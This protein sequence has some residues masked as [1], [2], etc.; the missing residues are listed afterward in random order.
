MVAEPEGA[1]EVFV[2]KGSVEAAARDGAGQTGPPMILHTRQSRRFARGGAGDVSNSDKKLAQFLRK[3]VMERVTMPAGYVHWSFDDADGARLSANTIGIPGGKYEAQLLGSASPAYV[4]GKWGRALALNGDQ[5]ARADFPGINQRN[6]RTVAFWVN[7]PTDALPSQA[8]SMI[9]WQQKGARGA[10][11]VNIGWNRNPSE[12]A[13]GAL[14]TDF[15]AGYMVGATPLRDGRWHHL[16]VVISPK[17]KTEASVQ[18]RQYVDGRLEDA[19]DHHPGKRA[20]RTLTAKGAERGYAEEALWIG[21]SVENSASDQQH[22]VGALD[23]LFV[24]DRAL[25]PQEIRHLM[26]KNAPAPAE[27]V[28][29]E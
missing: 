10:Y 11:P 8:D 16:A 29:L 2:L 4:A 27:T 6:S 22:L 9:S 7:I 5:F 26:K 1:T 13:F 19:S 25:S 24:A 18:V 28:A 21:C 14:R 15:G 23:E 17:R 3:I 20:H 12:G